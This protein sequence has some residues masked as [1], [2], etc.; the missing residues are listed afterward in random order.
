MELAA[1]IARNAAVGGSAKRGV[2]NLCV[3][4]VDDVGTVVN[5]A[6]QTAAPVA[7][8]CSALNRDVVAGH[9]QIAMVV[10]DK[11]A[12]ALIDIG[13]VD[14]LNAAVLEPI[15]VGCVGAA[16]NPAKQTAHI[17][18]A[19]S[20]YTADDDI[21]GAVSSINAHVAHRNNAATG[22]SGHAAGTHVIIGVLLHSGEHIHPRENCRARPL[23]R[24]SG[25]NVGVD[26]DIA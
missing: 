6:K 14:I 15:L 4:D 22:A 24:R 16:R 11:P 26:R 8:D 5:H 19:F 12:R 13:E 9:T 3:G 20:V 25:T 17:A 21:L 2:G 7:P 18:D 10:T 23:V 1:S